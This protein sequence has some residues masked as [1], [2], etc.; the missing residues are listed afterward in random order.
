MNYYEQPGQA[1]VLFKHV[2]NFS[3]QKQNVKEKKEQFVFAKRV[4]V[5]KL[6]RAR[7]HSLPYFSQN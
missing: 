1:L 2:E 3:K 4:C 5:F 7:K 6:K